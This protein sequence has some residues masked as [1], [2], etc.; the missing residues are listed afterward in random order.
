MTGSE[1]I[2]L[3]GTRPEGTAAEYGTADR[4]P[5]ESGTSECTVTEGGGSETRALAPGRALRRRVEAAVPPCIGGACG[6][7]AGLRIS[8]ISSRSLSCA[9]S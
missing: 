8:V 2:A 5:S 1:G 7:R 3:P 9:S 6:I 4:T